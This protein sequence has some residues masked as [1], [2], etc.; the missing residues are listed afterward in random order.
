MQ[1]ISTIT[2]L[3]DAELDTVSA[4][5]GRFL[6]QGAFGNVAV[7]IQV[8]PTVNVAL[9]SGAVWQSGASQSQI[10]NAGN[11]GSIRV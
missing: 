7:G 11:I 5:N 10:V 6:A 3:N 2:E 4:G 8:A 1:D 9:L